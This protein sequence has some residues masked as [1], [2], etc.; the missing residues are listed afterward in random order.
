[1]TATASQTNVSC[2]GGANGSASVSVSG[3]TGSYTYSWAPSG[4]SAATASG[5]S[6]GTYTVTVTDDNSCELTKTVTITQPAA[7]SASLSKTDVTTKG[8]TDGKATATVS[9]G[10][11]PYFYSW[12]PD[13]GTDA[14][15]SGLE[16][17]TYTCTITDGNNCE[18]TESVTIV[19]LNTPPVATAVSFSGIM[20][21]GQVLTGSYSYSDDDNDS[22]S[23]STF[24]WYRSTDNAGSDKI[25]ITGADGITYT[26]TTADEN[27]FISF[28]VTPND[29]ISSGSPVE[30]ALR[31][32]V[33]PAVSATITLDDENLAL[34]ESALVTVTFNRA[35]TGFTNDDLTVEHGTLSSVSSSDAGVTWK[36]TFTPDIGTEESTNTIEADLAGIS[37][38][39]GLSGT[40]SVS[41]ANFA[42]DTKRP[43]V[44]ISFSDNALRSGETATATFTF[45]ETVTGF[46]IADIDANH[47]TLA[48]LVTNDQITWIATFT[49]A[50]GI[51]EPANQVTVNQSGITDLAG[52][53][54]S[55]VIHSD[56]YKIDTKAPDAPGAPNLDV[57]SDSGNSDLDNLTN[58]T[59][60]ALTGMAEPNSNVAISRGTI[61]VGSVTA[62]AQGKWSMSIDTPLP[63]GTHEFT[64]IA[65]DLAGN[66]STT[67]PALTIVVDNTAPTSPSAT[68]LE[69]DSDTGVSDADNITSD[70]TPVLS[71]RADIGST[72]I[73]SSD[74][75]GT[76]GSTTADGSSGTWTF[77]CP[78]LSQGV[79]AISAKSADAAGNESVASLNLN[80]TI[81]NEAPLA[82]AVGNQT[83]P[84]EGTTDALSF[85]ISDNVTPTSN[86]T[87]DAG[88]SNPT[89]V[90]ASGLIFGGSGANRTITIT[91]ASPG[92]ATITI[93]LADMAGNLG[94]ETFVVTVNSAPIIDGSPATLV[95][96]DTPYSFIPVATDP[97][98]ADELIF[99]IE[100]KPSWA[101]FNTATG[102]LTGMPGRE[103]VGTYNEIIITVSDGTASSSSDPFKIEVAYVNAQ[104]S[105]IML[106]SGEIEENQPAGTSVGIFS[107]VDTDEQNTHSYQLVAGAGSTDNAFFYIDGNGLFTQTHFDSDVKDHY[108]IRVQTNDGDGGILEKIFEID[109]NDVEDLRVFVPN[110]FS[111]NGD[112]SNETFRVRAN[113]I[114]EI[115]LRIFD[116]WGNMVYQTTDVQD[117]TEIGWDGNHQGKQQPSGTYVWQ[118]IGKFTDGTP[119]LSSGKN[120]GNITLIR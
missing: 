16:A 68:D 57:L 96:Q 85:T 87:I 106:S 46:S 30:S 77:I 6:A 111:P 39:D 11:A 113:G 114:A 101:A 70:N 49:P 31:G 92:A 88:S 71:G 10:T 78:V 27:A 75:D 18:I 97:D 94:I 20:S 44:I 8:G 63:E 3:G 12:S 23:A 64:S 56:N 43:V 80:V 1:M 35:V 95:N 82:T 40:G 54:G 36:A 120:T 13:G 26:L 104:P 52:N 14:I 61:V 112:G 59:T 118:I 34:G 89:V 29:G 67:S 93:T 86:I 74:Q 28:E 21:T 102:A 90:P 24:K 79:H 109:I 99:S 9:G 55:G 50:P 45:S 65:T 98:E 33:K 100:N 7:I 73:I 108:Q 110:L 53:T 83:I 72:V 66:E 4:G 41:S 105:D 119:V 115:A 103:D 5:L 84:V 76:L 42:I 19:E 37:D 117:A 17:G 32:P 51:E 15:A 48:S 25:A 60:P 47:G 62:D 38:A 81:D 91:G 58:T 107:T 69:A 22:E 116:K 2:N